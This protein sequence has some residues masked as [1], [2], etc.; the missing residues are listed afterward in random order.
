MPKSTKY[1]PGDPYFICDICGFQKR[2]SE[3]RENWK[4]QKVCADTCWEPKHP[5]LTI[6]P[7]QERTAVL[8][9]RPEGDPVYLEVGDVTADDL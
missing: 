6:R 2:R 7:V 4:R 9:A 3:I 1:I 5:Q 8:G